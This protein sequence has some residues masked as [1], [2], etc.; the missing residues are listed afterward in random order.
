[1]LVTK[2]KDFLQTFEAYSG[3]SE[4]LAN[5]VSLSLQFQTLLKLR[6]DF[7]VECVFLELID[8]Y[9]DTKTIQKET[10]LNT[11]TPDITIHDSSSQLEVV[12]E[13]TLTVKK[14]IISMKEQKYQ[15]AFPDALV[16]IVDMTISGEEKLGLTSLVDI[17]KSFLFNT[18][19]VIQTFL[20]NAK[21]FG[22]TEELLD[23]FR[24]DYF[25]KEFKSLDS[26]NFEFNMKKDINEYLLSDPRETESLEA[27][28]DHITDAVKLCLENEELVEKFSLKQMKTG[29][30][31]E[32]YDDCKADISNKYILKD[33]PKPSFLFYS[34]LTETYG[35]REGDNKSYKPEDA[36][37]EDDH[38]NEQELLFIQLQELAKYKTPLQ[39]LALNS[40]KLLEC[41]STRNVF[42]NSV[43]LK[44]QKEPIMRKKYK[45]YKDTAHDMQRKKAGLSSLSF[46]EF[47]LYD[48]G[49]DIKTPC[50]SKT[51]KTLDLE[52][53]KFDPECQDFIRMSKTH[54]T[55]EDFVQTRMEKAIRNTS[56]SH[57]MEAFNPEKYLQE[58]EK[59]VEDMNQEI[60]PCIPKELF[61]MC[62][63][64][65]E[66]APIFKQLKDTS[67]NDFINFLR[68]I[69]VT[70]ML[71][72]IVDVSNHLNQLLHFQNMMFRYGAF[73]FFNSGVPDV[74]Y[75]V[76]HGLQDRG[77]DVGRSFMIVKFGTVTPQERVLFGFDSRYTSKKTGKEINITR[78]RRLNSQR[79]GFHLDQVYS[80]LSTTFASFARRLASC[81]T[82]GLSFELMQSETKNIFAIRYLTSMSHRQLFAEML[83]DIRYLYMDAFSE[84]ADCKEFIL[85]KYSKP[86][87]TSFEV[88]LFNQIPKFD[89]LYVNFRKGKSVTFRPARFE[90]TTRD[91]NSTGG[92]INLPS[93]LYPGVTM[94]GIQDLLDDMFLYVHTNKEPSTPYH[95]YVKAFKTIKKYQV[96]YDSLSREKKSGLYLN[97]EAVMKF[98]EEDNGVGF[99]GM[100]THAASSLISS[101]FNVNLV[102]SDVTN[103]ILNDTLLDMNS[104]KSIIPERE[105][106]CVTTTYSE[107]LVNQIGNTKISKKK[108]Q[109]WKEMAQ[110]DQDPHFIQIKTMKKSEVRDDLIVLSGINRCKVHDSTF[111]LVSNSTMK[112]TLDLALWNVKSNNSR[113]TTDICIKAQYGAKREFYV[114]NHGAKAQA[115]MMENAF[116]AISNHIEEEMISISGDKKMFNIQALLDKALLSS[117]GKN[118]KVFYCNGDCT[119]WS[120]AETMECLLKFTKGFENIIDDRIMKLLQETLLAW[121]EKEIFIPNDLMKNI[122][123]DL[124]G[125]T[126]DL[127]QGV[128]KST[129]NFLQGMFNYLSSCKA[130]ACSELTRSVWKRLYPDDLSELYHMEHS[131][132]YAFIFV[133]D[134][135]L[136]FKT[137]KIV[138]RMVMRFLGITDSTKKTN[139][140]Q[141]LLEFISLISFNGVMVY[142]QIKKIKEVGLNIGSMGYSSDIMTT[143]SRVGEACRVGVPAD[144]AYIMGR[145]QNVRIASAYGLFSHNRTLFNN[146]EKGH[147]SWTSLPVQMWG[148]P[149]VHP[150]FY[151]FCQGDPN[152]LRLYKYEPKSRSILHTLYKLMKCV[153]L[154]DDED[155]QEDRAQMV[156]GLYHPNYTYLTTS[157]LLK[158]IRKTLTMSLQECSEY[159]SKHP[160]DLLLKP[161]DPNRFIPWLSAKYYQKSFAEA[162]MRQG[163]VQLTLRLSSF[164]KQKCMS[165]NLDYS[166]LPEYFNIHHLKEENVNELMSLQEAADFIRDLSNHQIIDSVDDLTFKPCLYG[167]DQ[168]ANFIY[169]HFEKSVIEVAGYM[170]QDSKAYL[171][172]SSKFEYTCTSSPA[173]LLQ[174]LMTPEDFEKDS[175]APADLTVFLEDIKKVQKAASMLGI[176]LSNAGIR[177]MSIVYEIV[178]SSRSNRKPLLLNF[179]PL[180]SLQNCIDSYLERQ[181]V[182]SRFCLLDNKPHQLFQAYTPERLFGKTV[183][184]FE[185]PLEEGWEYRT[186]EVLNDGMLLLAF[187]SLN[188][189]DSEMVKDIIKDLTYRVDN[190]TKYPKYLERISNLY[191]LGE[192]KLDFV[193]AQVLCSMADF[194]NND[195]TPLAKYLDS[196]LGY[197]YEYRQSTP[198]R[199]MTTVHVCVLGEKFKIVFNETGGKD[200]HNMTVITDTLKLYVLPLVFQIGL[201]L[202]SAITQPELVKR[203]N[204]N[205]YNMIPTHD[206]LTGLNKGKDLYVNKLSKTFTFNP[207]PLVDVKMPV[208]LVDKLIMQ[209]PKRGDTH[210]GIIQF[211]YTSLSAVSSGSKVYTVQLNKLSQFN[212]WETSSTGKLGD[213][214]IEDL[215]TNKMMYKI[216]HKSYNVDAKRL[217]NRKLN[218]ETPR[219]KIQSRQKTE[220]KLTKE[221]D[222]EI[223]KKFV[224]SRMAKLGELF[225][226]SEKL[227]AYFDS[228]MT[229][230]EIISLLFGE[231][232]IQKSTQQSSLD[233][234]KL[235][236]ALDIT[237]EVNLDEFTGGYFGEVPEFMQGMSGDLEKEVNQ[238]FK[239]WRNKIRQQSVGSVN[240]VHFLTLNI[241]EDVDILQPEFHGVGINKK[242]LLE[243]VKTGCSCFKQE[244]SIES[245]EEIKQV[246]A[247]DISQGMPKNKP[248]SM[249]INLGVSE[250]SM[251]GMVSSKSIKRAP[252]KEVKHLTW[253]GLLNM[254]ELTKALEKANTLMDVFPDYACVLK[255][256]RGF[257]DIEKVPKKWRQLYFDLNHTG[258]TTRIDEHAI[259]KKIQTTDTIMDAPAILECLHSNG[260]VCP[261]A[262]SPT[263]T[264]PKPFCEVINMWGKSVIMSR[265]FSETQHESLR[266]LQFLVETLG[267]ELFVEKF[268]IDRVYQRFDINP[269]SLLE[270][271]EFMFKNEPGVLDNVLEPSINK[272]IL[273]RMKV[274][275]KIESSLS[276]SIVDERAPS[277]ITGMNISIISEPKYHDKRMVL[278]YVLRDA[279]DAIENYLTGLVQNA[280]L[281]GERFSECKAHSQLAII[282]MMD[283]RLKKVE[284]DTVEW[285][286]GNKCLE[287]FDT[288]MLGTT[289]L[290]EVKDGIFH[291]MRD[292]KSIFYTCNLVSKEAAES[293]IDTLAL[294]DDVD[295]QQEKK[296][297]LNVFI[298][299]DEETVHEGIEKS[300][301]VLLEELM[302]GSLLLENLQMRKN[303]D[304][305]FNRITKF[306]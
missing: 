62:Y 252:K 240:S 256:L 81:K 136:K 289:R 1:M 13:V 247:V 53:T 164:V 15:S 304:V 129:Q 195:P 125:V 109:L 77:K 265:Y 41:K 177:E 14:S 181:S 43:P 272:E 160:I 23:K 96:K 197:T 3:I 306:K 235:D 66:D 303:D 139:C 245:I 285:K 191:V 232:T 121:S 21:E 84:F 298:P 284:K 100:A 203:T 94:R 103:S 296:N 214:Y 193:Q 91:V 29:S 279:K 135:V 52:Y 168:T 165:L 99:W 120:A 251:A 167:F 86:I 261:L 243:C 56:G 260:C 28:I 292:N 33:V 108:I 152:N 26:Y 155:Y 79:V 175:N 69:A 58:I 111:D 213:F 44:Q 24:G 31:K 114:I 264:K 172:P 106:S 249:D 90:D 248:T 60:E 154:I 229:Q 205:M 202:M 72:N 216:I 45:E 273:E 148:I 85:D 42:D 107:E 110:V 230:G 238:V 206:C 145:I 173:I 123:Y 183:H 34:P 10:Y 208:I 179:D 118:T 71:R 222:I 76:Q 301:E 17:K 25:S 178:S 5:A 74:L 47:C 295:L 287:K 234:S 143:C 7:W 55:K 163:R 170:K 63:K 141:F 176:D 300:Y 161:R 80:V 32:A 151:L 166:K 82:R 281:G 159:W 78:W 162:Y 36:G 128:F 198:K 200:G 299:M 219:Y 64:V 244:R 18:E 221:K 196:K 113:V 276:Q 158:N 246:D 210:K 231:E 132:D 68:T 185:H 169:T 204:R 283:R 297:E 54:M 157:V 262:I 286:Y 236:Y 180:N 302:V 9:P 140:Q 116:K 215:L 130:V 212:C 171:Q 199:G 102:K 122:F 8:I 27:Q 144:V 217:L 192:L 2:L 6:H 271:N 237:L 194:V 290:R 88:Y 211:N 201:R 67:L 51:R 59:Y 218:P 288:H 93:L 35:M 293:A 98:L 133:T 305:F 112:T 268:E 186:S 267:L 275:D 291:R 117:S 278:P 11:Y 294:I 233:Y 258:G 188:G 49:K 20:A 250:V 149:D 184:D 104:T 189:L 259:L 48:A 266:L 253:H 227:P 282:T 16:V 220:F 65:G 138:H 277:E 239:R 57:K 40:V 101:R 207:N 95:E 127:K 115:R 134:D 174:Y 255:A 156:T 131:D 92:S 190:K 75:I 30:F 182:T 274:E 228:N 126:E 257:K 137:F 153:K 37:E 61:R 4:E 223:N 146:V 187:A 87:R 19:R 22:L 241:E 226:D 242:K 224:L 89:E 46:I 38:L 263:N 269:P 225:S 270:W 105:R 50:A 83:A 254:Q 73:S 119:K 147:Y 70:P 280:Y 124:P 142:P 209:K 12:V 39:S 97:S 150:I